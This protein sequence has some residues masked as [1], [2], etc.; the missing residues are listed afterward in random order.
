VDPSRLRADG[1]ENQKPHPRLRSG[2][3]P[4]CHFKEAKRL[5]NLF[6]K[7]KGKISPCGRDDITLAKKMRCFNL[8]T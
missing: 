6:R 4:D 5:R 7:Q 2:I 3:H 8:Y 1:V